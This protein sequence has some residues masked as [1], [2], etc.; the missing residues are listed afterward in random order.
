MRKVGA[1]LEGARARLAL[2]ARRV[3]VAAQRT[4]D[5]ATPSVLSHGRAAARAR[6]KEAQVALVAVRRAAAL[7]DVDVRVKGAAA[8]LARVVRGVVRAAAHLRVGG[9]A[10]R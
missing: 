1:A 2:E 9:E 8:A 7:E 10:V 6:P 5:C 4:D 3:P